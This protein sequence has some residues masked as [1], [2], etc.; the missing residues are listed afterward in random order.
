MEWLP[1]ITT[2]LTGLI[3]ILLIAVLVHL[4]N[5]RNNMEEVIQKLRV[6][7][8]VELLEEKYKNKSNIPQ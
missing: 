1:L 3:C 2:I 5:V 7:L 4:E 8:T 6:V